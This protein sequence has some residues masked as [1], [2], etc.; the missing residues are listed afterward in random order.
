MGVKPGQG[1]AAGGKGGAGGG[2]DSISVVGCKH[3]TIGV[4]VR[5]AFNRLGENHGKPTY[6]KTAQANGEDVLI[7]FWDARDGEA[8]SGWWF[9][10]KVGGDQVWAY[11]ANKTSMVPPPTGWRVPFNG[12]IDSS[13]QLKSTPA[14]A[15]GGMLSPQKPGAPGMLTPGLKPGG[16]T[17]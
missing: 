4:T 8:F 6:K 14:G 10:P 1:A 17:P 5:G 3:D 7:Y 13:M 16:M 2:Q 11:H 15:A 12:D 9:G